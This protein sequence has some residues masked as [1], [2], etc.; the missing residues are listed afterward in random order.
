MTKNGTSHA[1]T[2]RKFPSLFGLLLI[3]LLPSVAQAAAKCTLATVAGNYAVGTLGTTSGG[4]GSGVFLT[5]S[6]GKGNLS[7]TGYES[8]NGTIYSNVTAA[9][10][11]TVSSDCWFS[12][13]TTDSIGNVLN[14][15]G[16][17][18]SKWC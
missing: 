7:A 18:C 9:G 1:F 14:I 15:E 12:S 11:Y 3:A 6:D 8:D 16:R 13:S 5:T 10:T 2:S 4:Y 17:Y